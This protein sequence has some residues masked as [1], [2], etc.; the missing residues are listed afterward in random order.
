M[1]G[2]DV[3]AVV[4]GRWALGT[5]GSSRPATASTASPTSSIAAVA[6]RP[7]VTRMLVPSAC[8]SDTTSRSDRR[9][10]PLPAA[11]GS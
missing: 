8:D 7:D 6:T 11:A 1:T 9:P 5:D 4:A 2:A 3:A 10:P